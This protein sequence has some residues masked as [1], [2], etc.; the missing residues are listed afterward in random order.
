MARSPRAVRFTCISSVALLIALGAA[1]QARGHEELRE[2][3]FR[4]ATLGPVAFPTPTFRHFRSREAL[5][6]YVSQADPGRSVRVPFPRDADGILVTT[7]PRS[8]TGYSVEIDRL[9][10]ERSRVVVY[11]VEQTP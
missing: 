10:E 2:V 3:P 7:G 8:S 1:W 6:R 4:T 11:A 5:V 9:V